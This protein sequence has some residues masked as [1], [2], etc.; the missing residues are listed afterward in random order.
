MSWRS[1]TNKIFI[2]KTCRVG[3]QQREDTFA[4]KLAYVIYYD[5]KG[6][7]RKEKSWE[8]WRHEVGGKVG[9]YGNGEKVTEDVAPYDFPN[10]PT[11]G[12]VLNK[13]HTRYAWSSFGSKTTVI[14]IYDPRGIEF[15]ITPENLVALLMHTDCSHREIQGELVYAW[16]GTELMLLPCSSEEYKAAT[17]YSE[18]QGKRISANYLKDGYTYITKNEEELIYLGRHM[19]YEIKYEYD[20]EKIARVG[21]KMH[22]FY[23]PN[24]KGDDKWATK[25]KFKPIRSVP[26]T[27]SKA[28]S[29]GCHDDFASLVD[30]F[31][32]TEEAGKIVAW[33]KRPI[34]PKEWEKDWDD[35]NDYGYDVTMRVAV[36]ENGNFHRVS[37]GRYRPER[38]LSWLSNRSDPADETGPKRLAFSYDGTVRPDGACRDHYSSFRYDQHKHTVIDKAKFFHLYAVFDTGIK[39]KWS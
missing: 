9:Y 14:R 10:E 8:T 16:C 17:E 15:E 33:E 37:I 27:I 3:F 12:F 2:P 11:S 26:N 30:E 39:R 35:K 21:K 36:E 19:W 7:L 1:T 13:G 29:D 38:G 5:A 31:L 25:P 6:K 24:W 22:I 20:E 18:L 32:K 28:I 34:K 4:N 23:D